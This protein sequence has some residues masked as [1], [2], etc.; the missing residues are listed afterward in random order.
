MSRPIM[1]YTEVVIW[2]KYIP[3]G[4]GS[5]CRGSICPRKEQENDLK[6]C[7]SIWKVNLGIYSD[8]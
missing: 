6:N 2:L 4:M 3:V 7:S 1:I 8:H 5:Q